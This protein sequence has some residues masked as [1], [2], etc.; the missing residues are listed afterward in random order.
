MRFAEDSPAIAPDTPE[1][2][3]YN[4]I[5]R[6]LEFSDFAL[7][8]AFLSDSFTFRMERCLARLGLPGRISELHS[9]GL[10]LRFH[11]A[12][13]RQTARHRTR[14]LRSSPG[15]PL[16]THHPEDALLAMGRDQG[17]PGRTPVCR[18]HR[19]VA[20]FH[21]PP[22]AAALVDSFLGDVHGTVR[23]AGANRSPHPLSD[24]LQIRAAGERRL[25]AET[26]SG[27]AR[28]PAQ[29]C[30]ASTNGIFPKRVARRMQL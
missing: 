25:E 11:A 23:R 6:W 18:H 20:L 24:L 28:A 30:A 4:R 27:S 8:L 1:A 17:L 9:V 16:S 29:K 2:R 26:W 15:T 7:G 3:R 13:G 19:R 22:I 12:A 14:L 5:H 10:H 21:H